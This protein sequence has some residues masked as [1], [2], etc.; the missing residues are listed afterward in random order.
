M[1]FKA[2][3][4]KQ[5]RTD[6]ALTSDGRIYHLKVVDRN[7]GPAEELGLYVDWKVI[8]STG[9]L[10]ENGVE[11]W[12][13]DILRKEHFVRWSRKEGEITETLTSIVEWSGD[14]FY[15]KRITPSSTYVMDV[16]QFNVI[17]NIFENPELI[18]ATP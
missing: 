1:K 5:W 6:F 17:G 8:R 18:E 12:E 10:D 2:W 13:G 9:L 11:I 3:D 7:Y 4:G 15:A 14:G 16:T